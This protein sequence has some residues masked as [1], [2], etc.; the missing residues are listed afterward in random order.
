MSLKYSI[1]EMKNMLNPEEPALFYA[2]SQVREEIDIY[3]L[4]REMSYSTTLTDGDILNVVFALIHKTN[5]HLAQGDSVSLGEFGKFQM[6]VSSRGAQT[7]DDFTH[8]NIKKV[9]VQFRPGRMIRTAVS[10]YKY[11]RVISV[12]ARKEALKNG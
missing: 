2:R 7:K 3:Q 9:K 6:Q 11:E 10:D 1:T 5:E 12:K 4:A 8:A